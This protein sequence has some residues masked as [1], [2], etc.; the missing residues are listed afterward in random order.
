[1]AAERTR[2]YIGREI[3][4][5]QQHCVVHRTWDMTANK[6]TNFNVTRFGSS[7]EYHAC[8]SSDEPR[9]HVAVAESSQ[10]KPQEMAENPRSAGSTDFK[11]PDGGGASPRKQKKMSRQKR[12]DYGTTLPL[13]FHRAAQN[14]AQAAHKK[15]AHQTRKHRAKKRRAQTTTREMADQAKITSLCLAELLGGAREDAN[16]TWIARGLSGSCHRNA[17]QDSGGSTCQPMLLCASTYDVTCVRGC[18]FQ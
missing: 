14:A 8:E 4:T 10:K 16:A 3:H 17:C 5:T 7:G 15:K 9:L 12:R 6:T 11:A 1:M 2:H 13:H 18:R